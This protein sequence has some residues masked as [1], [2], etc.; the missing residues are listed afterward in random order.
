MTFE[1]KT[2]LAISAIKKK[3]S[4]HST[5][6]RNLCFHICLHIWAT[7]SVKC[8]QNRYYLSRAWPLNQ[9]ITSFKGAIK[10]STI[11]NYIKHVIGLVPMNTGPIFL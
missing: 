7:I 6:D 5:S 3:Y 11:F 10:I 4:I 9:F 8:S 1:M 2:W